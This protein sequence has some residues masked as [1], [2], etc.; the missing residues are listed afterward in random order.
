MTVGT[1]SSIST[2]YIDN[3]FKIII[4]TYI[5]TITYNLKTIPIAGY[6]KSEST[7]SSETFTK[8]KSTSRETPIL[9][10]VTFFYP[11][12]VIRY[13]RPDLSDPITILSPTVSSLTS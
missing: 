3:V 5:R 10:I 13:I 11:T 4:F 9:L 6:E 12:V 1:T 7:S 8:S 2:S